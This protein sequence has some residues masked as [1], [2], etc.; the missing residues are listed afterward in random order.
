MKLFL[1]WNDSIDKLICSQHIN[2]LNGYPFVVTYNCINGILCSKQHALP[3]SLGSNVPFK[4]SPGFIVHKHT[5]KRLNNITIVFDKE[6]TFMV[7]PCF[8]N[9]NTLF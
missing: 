2:S 4:A 9:H 8:K 1:L 6:T 7:Q 3:L 5:R